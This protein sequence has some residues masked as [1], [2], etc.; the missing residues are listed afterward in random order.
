MFILVEAHYVMAFFH[1][2]EKTK[3]LSPW[4]RKSYVSWYKPYLY[5]LSGALEQVVFAFNFVL[6]IRKGMCYK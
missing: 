4:R 2:Q 6:I 1:R 3:Y 5:S